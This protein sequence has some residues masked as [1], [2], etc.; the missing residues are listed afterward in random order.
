MPSA[1][2]FLTFPV[3]SP[4]LYSS[5][6]RKGERGGREVEARTQKMEGNEMERRKEEI[7]IFRSGETESVMLKTLIYSFT[8]EAQ[9]LSVSYEI[10]NHLYPNIYKK[11]FTVS[12][13]L[14]NVGEITFKKLQNTIHLLFLKPSF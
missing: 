6:T 1:L 7:K 4:F 12:N 9:S 10:N 8:H 3:D 5:D 13:N 2:F 11:I 14:T